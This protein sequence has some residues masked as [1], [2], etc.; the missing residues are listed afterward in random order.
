M[1]I[2]RLED[3]SV[4]YF[5]K[6]GVFSGYDFIKITDEYPDTNLT[7]PTVSVENGRIDVKDYQLGDRDGLRVRRWDIDIFAKNKSQRD[8][9]GYKLLNDL[10]NGIPVY[11]YNEGFP[12]S[13]TPTKVGVLQV[14]S[15]TYIPIKVN[16]GIS[17]LLYYRATVSFVAQDDVIQE[18]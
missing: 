13:S 12:P 15:K 10:K 2:E 8:D 1:F 4:F 9:F 5:L 3:L 18:V 7:L 16:S 6:D 17:E 11:N 14:I